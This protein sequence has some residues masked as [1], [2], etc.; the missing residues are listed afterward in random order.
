MLLQLWTSDTLLSRHLLC[1]YCQ[2]ISV[3]C[4]C[5][6]CRLFCGQYC[7]KR[8]RPSSLQQT[9][10]VARSIDTCHENLLYELSTTFG[11]YPIRHWI[12]VQFGKGIASKSAFFS[13]EHVLFTINA[14]TT[15]FTADGSGS[16]S[17]VHHRQF[18]LWTQWEVRMSEIVCEE[19]LTP[20]QHI[21]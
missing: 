7:Q 14:F 16:I 6:C 9:K 2:R 5:Y 3:L 19:M 10:P 1:I 12:P 17:T 8:S 15:S 13:I 21:P 4:S 20:A 18:E 11:N